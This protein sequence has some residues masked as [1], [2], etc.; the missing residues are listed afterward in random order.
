MLSLK[1][2]AAQADILQA[3]INSAIVTAIHFEIF[4]KLGDGISTL[5][6]IAENAKAEEYLILRF[7]RVLVVAGLVEE[8]DVQK[9]RN[10]P[11][12][13]LIS[14]DSGWES[15]FRFM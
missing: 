7:M 3:T 12:G 14:E 15:G 8:V 1:K 9:Y 2:T 13:Q 5:K 4:K 6:E 10:L 11:P